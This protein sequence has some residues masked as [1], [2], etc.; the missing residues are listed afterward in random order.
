MLAWGDFFGRPALLRGLRET[1]RDTKARSLLL[2]AMHRLKRAGI[3]GRLGRTRAWPTDGRNESFAPARANSAWPIAYSSFRF[4]PIGECPNS[5]V[6]VSPS[7][8]SNRTSRSRFHSPI[9][10]FEVLLCGTCL[11]ASTELIAKLPAYGRLPHGYGCVAIED[12]DDIAELAEALAAIVQDQ[13]PIAAVGKRGR[14][15]ACRAQQEMP[16]ADRLDRILDAAAS[17]QRLRVGTKGLG[18]DAATKAHNYRFSLT[19]L[20]AVAITDTALRGG[21]GPTAGQGSVGDLARARDVLAGIKQRIGTGD[22]RLKPFVEAI[23]TEVAIA[24]AETKEPRV[25]PMAA[26]PFFGCTS[27]DGQWQQKSS[28]ASSLCVTR[29][30][31]FS[32]ST[33]MCLS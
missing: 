6:A 24:T 16:I 23:E 12:V 10:P 8:V 15:F 33:M 27:R 14:S 5:C 21:V 28:A 25:S 17:R 32:N 4:F 2:A 11:V 3:R 1:R 31:V 30:C 20:A 29:D 13:K 26:A 9:I 19:Q 7:A 18:D 22:L